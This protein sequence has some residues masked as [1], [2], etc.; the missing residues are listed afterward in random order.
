MNTKW[1]GALG[2]LLMAWAASAFAASPAGTMA[3]FHAA[4]KVGDRNGALAL[5]SPKVVIYESGYVELT[6]EEYA[7]RHLDSDI[8][9]SKSTTST[10]LQQSERIAGDMASVLEQSETTGQFQGK[11]VHAVSL[12]TALLEKQGETWVIVHLHWSS[13]K[14]K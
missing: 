9:F 2:V 1:Q 10:S 14:L 13:R 8:A 6:R 3:A 12:E 11:P 5:M 4:L 7:N